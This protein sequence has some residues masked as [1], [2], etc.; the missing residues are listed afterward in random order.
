MNR[1]VV[2]VRDQ[3]T[4]LCTF[5]QMTV[6]FAALAIV[7]QDEAPSTEF[8]VRVA[9]NHPG[10]QSEVVSFVER[11]GRRHSLC[12]VSVLGIELRFGRIP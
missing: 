4:S 10:E 7:L 8:E 9:L 11:P 12:H 3:A 2:W 1:L 6:T 5:W